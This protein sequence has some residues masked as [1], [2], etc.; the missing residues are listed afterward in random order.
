M[1]LLLPPIRVAKEVGARLGPGQILLG[2]LSNCRFK[3]SESVGPPRT[4]DS[5]YI[6]VVG[7]RGPR[8]WRAANPEL[9][10]EERERLTVDLMR[11][12]RAVRDAADAQALAAARAR[13]DAVKVALGERGPVWWRDGAP[14]LN[15]RL[16]KNTCY[17]DWWKRLTAA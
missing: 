14:D 1:R 17:A 9:D 16:I 8:L 15:R 6:V 2:S 5:R 12:R 3:V 11:A 4:P 10:P 7:S 13:V